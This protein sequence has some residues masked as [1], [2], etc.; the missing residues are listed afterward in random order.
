MSNSADPAKGST[1]AR[2]LGRR[3]PG[4]DEA[5]RGKE[6]K[7]AESLLGKSIILEGTELQ[8]SCQDILS[9]PGYYGLAV[10]I[11]KQNSSGDK[12]P[13]NNIMW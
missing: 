3:A 13:H 12:T 1:A 6:S 7:Q 9:A 2:K 4:Q 10:Q 8:E 5:E 11:N